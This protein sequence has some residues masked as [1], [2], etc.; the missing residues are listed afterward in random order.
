MTVAIN[1][2]VFAIAGCAG[3]QDKTRDNG[4]PVSHQRSDASEEKATEK[5]VEEE[6]PE[7]TPE[8][9]AA[10]KK[11]A[12]E[13]AAADKAAADKKASDE[14]KAK[15]MASCE[16]AS[17][18]PRFRPLPDPSVPWCT[19]DGETLLTF[20]HI[21][22]THV[23]KEPPT[24]EGEITRDVDAFAAI[25]KAMNAMRTKTEPAPEFAVITGDLTD[26]WRSSDIRTFKSML[27]D[28]NFPSYVC[29]GNHDV[30]F[31][32][33][34]K[35]MKSWKRWFPKA[36]LPQVIERGPIVLIGYDSQIYNARRKSEEVDDIATRQWRKIQS[37]VKE[38]HAA[39]KRTFLFA[40]IPA[41]PSLFRKKVGASWSTKYLKPFQ[42]LMKK[43][44]VEASLTGH[45]HRD[46]LYVDGKTFFLNAP[47]VSRWETRDSSYRII[48]V[49]KTGLAYRQIYIGPEAK[50]RS[51]EVDLRG[52]T[53]EGMARWVDGLD[54]AGLR[55]V[56]E[57]RYA[58][59]DASE[60]MY[61]E[62]L[63]GHF[64]KFL[65]DPFSYQ[66]KSGRT[67]RLSP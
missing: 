16:P 34:T 9:L 13:E 24:D 50:T 2:L 19:D 17:D 49:M 63:K 57:M 59:D 25:V 22:D 65:K 32:P 10:E 66:P 7:K 67:R 55:K 5:A 44:E 23:G 1:A 58:G 21:T 20:F 38:A 33:Q 29:S 61:G 45:F 11:A 52:V 35:H 27:E 54:D 64:R 62:Q 26:G 53:P 4:P 43:Y 56:W 28:L 60:R 18:A 41:L 8:A 31:D 37:A 39:G 48:R 6:A 15:V 30:T 40:H 47:P 12:D 14:G 36:T 3:S 46:E 51:Y 42:R